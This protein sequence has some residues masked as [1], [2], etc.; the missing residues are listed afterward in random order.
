METLVKKLDKLHKPWYRIIIG[1]WQSRDHISNQIL[2]QKL[3]NERI[4]DICILRK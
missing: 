3:E 1:I 4:L 2:Y